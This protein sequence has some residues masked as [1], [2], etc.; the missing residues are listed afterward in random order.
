MLNLL[1]HWKNQ[2]LP[3]IGICVTC[4]A[5][6]QNKMEKQQV[7]KFISYLSPVSFASI[8][9]SDRI[10]QNIST[11]EPLLMQTADGGRV[12]FVINQNPLKWPGENEKILHDFYKANIEE[13]FNEVKFLQ[14]SIRKINGKKFIVF[15]F[16]G[17]LQSEN[18]FSKK[19][20]Q[21]YTYIQYTMFKS[22]I[23]IFS[24]WCD[25]QLMSQW[26]PT[27]KEVMESV[28]ITK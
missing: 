25:A 14:D 12:N 8:V 19:S 16:I 2:I 21:T 27:A 13:L 9:E 15:E 22:R 17:A 23:L 10:R 20:S 26:R 18:V 7:G 28:T 1:F 5:F 6:A 11:R 4:I 24:L 3:T